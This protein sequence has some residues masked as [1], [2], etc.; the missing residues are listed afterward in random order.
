MSRARRRKSG[1]GEQ[2][3]KKRKK[4]KEE[5]KGKEKGWRNWEKLLKNIDCVQPLPGPHC[6]HR[7]LRVRVGVFVI[8]EWYNIMLCRRRR[9]RRRAAA[10]RVTVA[11]A[12]A[13]RDLSPATGNPRGLPWLPR[14]LPRVATPCGKRQQ[15]RHRDVRCSRTLRACL[16]CPGR[17]AER[18]G[19]FGAQKR[20]FS[21]PPCRSRGPSV[22]P[23]VRPRASS[24]RVLSVRPTGITVSSPALPEPLRTFS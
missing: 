10:A 24:P 23:S 9:W 7:S 22:R 20:R 21:R 4:K 3:K 5:E 12:R 16:F 1:G 19:L 18:L 15:L 11:A 2:T 8:T 17:S 13:F 14:G 6:R